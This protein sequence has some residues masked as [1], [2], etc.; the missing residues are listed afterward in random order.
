MVDPTQDRADRGPDSGRG[1]LLL[2]GW[3]A[4]G[5]PAARQE[6]GQR[7]SGT[8]PRSAPRNRRISLGCRV[9]PSIPSNRLHNGMFC[10][11]NARASTVH[12]RLETGLKWFR[13]NGEVDAVRCRGMPMTGRVPSHGSLTVDPLRVRGG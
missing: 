8:W 9:D 2:L 4:S 10:V 12:S 6:M 3:P 13:A 5:C 7:G 1:L 11:A